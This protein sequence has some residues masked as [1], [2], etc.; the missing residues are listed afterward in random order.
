MSETKKCS[1]CGKKKP[2]TVEFFGPNVNHG[3]PCLYSV[4]KVCCAAQRRAKRAANPEPDRLIARRSWQKHRDKR[5]AELTARYVNNPE[6]Y[7]AKQREYG[8]A[9]RDS[10]ATTVKQWRAALKAEMH[11]A[12]GARCACCGETESRFLTLE[13][14]RRDGGAHRR[15]LGGQAN[16]YTALKRAGWPKDGYTLLCWNCQM[17][18]SYGKSCPHTALI[19]VDVYQEAEGLFLH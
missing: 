15:E 8:K 1:R 9:N 13:H 17:S 16:V 4:C 18:T 3:R 19:P 11:A 10:I 14:T 6:H 2:A 12:Y 7:R 5:V